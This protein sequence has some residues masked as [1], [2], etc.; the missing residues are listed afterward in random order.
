MS[1]PSP[2]EESKYYKIL[3]RYVEIL[4]TRVSQELLKNL[5]EHYLVLLEN[6]EVKTWSVNPEHFYDG[7][8]RIIT[9]TKAMT[10]LSKDEYKPQLLALLHLHSEWEYDSSVCV[11]RLDKPYS[12]NIDF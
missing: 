2:V 8:K 12:S 6:S 4:P 7:F 3:R 9:Y 11:Y 10:Y 1:Q 5:P